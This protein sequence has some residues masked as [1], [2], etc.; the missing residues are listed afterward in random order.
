MVRITTEFEGAPPVEVER[1]ITIPIEEEID[2]GENVFIVD[3]TDATHHI[4]R[5][6]IEAED[7]D[8]QEE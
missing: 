2:L 1:Q 3:P 5:A 4:N 7:G 8:R 6:P